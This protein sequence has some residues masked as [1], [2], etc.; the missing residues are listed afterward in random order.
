M[1]M[2]IVAIFM[3][4]SACLSACYQSAPG[5]DLSTDGDA[6]GDAQDDSGD[7]PEMTDDSEACEPSSLIL[8]PVSCLA[9]HGFLDCERIRV[10][11]I[12]VLLFE[13]GRTVMDTILPR[14]GDTVEVGAVEPGNYELSAICDQEDMAYA[15]GIKRLRALYPDLPECS[16][17]DPPCTSLLVAIQPCATSIVPLVLNCYQFHCD[18]CCGF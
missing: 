7:E 3:S 1:A 2:R 15:S 8:S 17:P 4:M 14:L 11:E 5:R 18:D 9:F 12:R 6:Y 13:G 10:S 16:E